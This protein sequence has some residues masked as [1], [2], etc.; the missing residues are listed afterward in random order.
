TPKKVT[1]TKRDS[2]GRP[3][4]DA[5]GQLVKVTVDAYEGKPRPLGYL[6]PAVQTNSILVTSKRGPF[7]STF[8]NGVLAAQW[9]RNVLMEDGAIATNELMNKISN[10]D[11]PHRKYLAGDI[12]PLLRD[13]F[14]RPGKFSLALY[15]LDDRE[16]L[17][18]LVANASKIDLILA[19]SGEEDGVW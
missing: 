7:Q 12:I 6:G 1:V 9:L 16:L 13:F 17:D 11:D 5:N 18:L 8:T 14:A 4:K 10:P 2:D 3:I 15:E 19:N